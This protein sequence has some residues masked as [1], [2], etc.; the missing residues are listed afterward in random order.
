MAKKT[1]LFTFKVNSYSIDFLACF[2]YDEHMKLSGTIKD[3]IFRNNENDY[4]ILEISQG[5]FSSIA[6]GKFPIIGIGE[7]VELEGEYQNNPKYGSQFVASKIKISAPTDE[8]SI[9][10]YL[11]S[12]LIS[13]VGVVTATNIVSMF[14]EKTLKVIEEDPK[15]LSKVKGVSERKAI[16]ISQT[17]GNIKKMQQA[18]MFLQKYEISTNM[19]VKIFEV[20]KDKTEKIMSQNPYKLIEDVEGIGFKTADKIAFN[21]GI[22]KDSN[23]RIRAG[24]LYCLSELA[25]KQ[26][27]TVIER[28]KLAENVVGLLELPS[29]YQGEALSIITNLEIEGLVKSTTI[30]EQSAVAITKLYNMEKFIA[31]KLKMLLNS[32]EELHVDVDADIAEFERVNNIVLHEGQKRAIKTAVC[33]GVVVITGGPGTGKTTIIKAILNIL[34]KRGMKTTLLA[35]TGRASKRMEEQTGRSAST[36]HRGLEMAY[37]AGRLGFMRN[38]NNPLETDAII[39]DEVSMLDLYVANALLKATKLGTKL[40]F[41]GDK[42][43]L[44]SV[45]AGNV[46][47]DIIESDEIPVV[48]LSQIYRQEE[49]SMIIVNAHKINNS[50]MPDLLKK[51][52]DFFYSSN[53]VPEIVA[54]EIV[55]MV[56]KRIPN[57]NKEI[58]CKDIQ[59]I[60]PMKSGVAGTNNLN[61]LLRERLNP[62]APGKEEIELHKTIFRVGDKVMQTANNYEQEWIKQENGILVSG[63][64]VFNGDMGY[65][66]QINTK[67]GEVYVNFDD[68]R[69]AGY[70][71]V[72]L[73]DLVH[74]YAITIHKSQ[75]S[76]F[77]VVIIPILGGN[78][79]LYTKNLLYTAVTRAKKMVV[80]IGKQSNIFHMIKNQYL[81]KR[82]TLL[83]K[84]LMTNTYALS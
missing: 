40:I 70:S 33:Q 5:M 55:D 14:K 53:F 71:I 61:I 27:S 45:G 58:S 17:F 43:Q 22:Q 39:V 49:S 83:K 26:G 15:L 13:G 31:E 65:I 32:N 63:M 24:I 69:R 6:T 36:I 79:M 35:P 29:E 28:D 84:F 18:V 21:M 82:E 4:T 9:I 62:K 23:F 8:Q 16:E 77:D 7:E 60:V 75:G 10:N 19:A 76:E 73:E 74:A 42:D 37:N 3:I 12:G 11:S 52:Q 30:G 66:D 50:E 44:M 1:K 64:G 25:E 59:V 41:V 67:S 47:S 56:D 54:N 72:E 57:Y 81:V 2:L 80:L 20:Y 51:S 38:E 68:G 78:P 46:L 48:M 34:S